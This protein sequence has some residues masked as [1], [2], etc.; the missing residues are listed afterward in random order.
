MK[1]AGVG[2]YALVNVSINLAWLFSG[3]EAA[4]IAADGNH[5]RD[6]GVS[7]KVRRG[8]PGGKN[9]HD[10]RKEQKLETFGSLRCLMKET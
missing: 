1:E 4:S 2:I 5:S 8:R 9:C 10:C 7:A 6:L 3:P